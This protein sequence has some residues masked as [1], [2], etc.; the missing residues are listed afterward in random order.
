[1]RRRSQC[2]A[3]LTILLTVLSHALTIDEIQFSTAGN[4][5][6]SPYDGEIVSIVGGIVTHK[7]GFRIT[8]QDPA[9]GDMWA[10]IELRA[11]ENEAPLGAVS[12]G[13]QVDFF[14]VFVEEFRG[15]TIPQFKNY[16]TFSIQSSG[17]SLPEPITLPVA[18]LADPPQRD[19]CEP[20]EGMLVAVENVR[21]GEMDWGKAGDNYELYN[22]TSSMW[23][24][25][26]ANL[27]LAVPPFP[28]Y[29]VRQGERYARV[30]GI[31]QEYL[32]PQ[33]SWDYYQLLPRGSADYEKS[34]LYT[35]R[36]IQESSAAEHWRSAYEGGRVNLRA[37]VSAVLPGKQMITLC[38]PQLGTS[39]AGISVRDTETR[40]GDL[41]LGDE[42]QLQHVLVAE[43]ADL[44]I[45]TFDAE[46]ELSVQGVGASVPATPIE[47]ED[48]ARGAE[49]AER[50]ESMLVTLFNVT[51]PACGVAEGA[52]LYYL[53]SATD[54]LLC[55]DSAHDLAPPGSA[56]FVRPG[57]R[58]GRIR[59]IVLEVPV[60]GGSAYVLH[61]RGAR[62]YS[63]VAGEEKFTTWGRLKQMYR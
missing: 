44:T 52:D 43:Q 63:F 40:L 21:V 59:G 37:I 6:R 38:D 11:F 33:E 20:Y 31:L 48:L 42:I 2:L 58:L 1:M 47:P 16:S 27:D 50:Y 12:V 23:A 17:H 22:E 35:I 49:Y 13:D 18:T 62:D 61:P 46:S 56:F 10:G 36:D 29:H 9:A 8:L 57:D 54:T 45:L 39:W 15:G 53:V 25:D 7:I 60:E 32:Y 14:D 30:V 51:V 26:Y 28:T 3:M 55:S 24:S 41:L 19:L 4:G 5:W 34:E